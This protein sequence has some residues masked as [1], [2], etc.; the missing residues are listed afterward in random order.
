MPQRFKNQHMVREAQF[1]QALIAPIRN[2]I[3]QPALAAPAARKVLTEVVKLAIYSGILKIFNDTFTNT[4]LGALGFFP[5]KAT[6]VE[7]VLNRVQSIGEFKKLSASEQANLL[8][9]LKELAQKIFAESNARAVRTMADGLGISTA[10]AEQTLK[11]LATSSSDPIGIQDFIN[12]IND[13]WTEGY[14]TLVPFDEFKNIVLTVYNRDKNLDTVK[15]ILKSI[16]DYTKKLIDQASEAFIDPKEIKDLIL[17]S[18]DTRNTSNLRQKVLEIPFLV[19][20]WTGKVGR[21]TA[22]DMAIFKNN[23][24]RYKVAP[25]SIEKEF[26]KYYGS[27]AKYNNA[28]Y[29]L[30]YDVAKS[31]AQ[32][33]TVNYQDRANFINSMDRNSYLFQEA[34][35]TLSRAQSLKGV[36]ESN[37]TILGEGPVV[38]ELQKRSNTDNNISTRYSYKKNKNKYVIA[39]EE[40]IKQTGLINELNKYLNNISNLEKEINSRLSD[41]QSNIN[42]KFNVSS[43][44]IDSLGGLTSSVFTVDTSDISQIKSNIEQFDKQ[45][46]NIDSFVSRIAIS[47]PEEREAL[48]NWNSTLRPKYKFQSRQFRNQLEVFDILMPYS[49]KWNLLSSVFINNIKSLQDTTQ[50]EFM[51]GGAPTAGGALYGSPVIIF[52]I[53]YDEDGNRTFEPV[54]KDRYQA[55]LGVIGQGLDL[56]NLAEQIIS[57]FETSLSRASGNSTLQ[58]TLLLAMNQFKMVPVS[59]QKQ[60]MS[61][62]VSLRKTTAPT[63][64]AP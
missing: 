30:S 39:A 15:S 19:F 64:F 3:N 35:K 23:I 58:K 42:F 33:G 57:A 1:W 52:D 63:G 17:E 60:I 24:D 47:T 21:P 20:L 22:Q 50:Q 46:Q 51:G 59:I 26:N 6:K 18:I 37:K 13:N 48:D 34:L 40:G 45:I 41:L 14:Q 62:Q 9:T 53:T 31:F 61:V 16:S 25:T 2:V 10:T 43:D 27:V 54:Q 11:T 49:Q 5:D 44:G 12:I 8:E 28:L 55:A 38:K 4:G 29:E 32:F 36:V 7:E 56:Y